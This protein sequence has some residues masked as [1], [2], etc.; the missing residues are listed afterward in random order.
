MSKPMWWRIKGE[1]GEYALNMHHVVGI[2]FDKLPEPL[3]LRK[4]ENLGVDA[5]VIQIRL[6]DGSLLQLID[7]ADS[8]AGVE[9]VI[10]VSSE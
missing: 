10:K 8:R 1:E 9:E 6:V 7:N 3:E 2:Y 4:E 5:R